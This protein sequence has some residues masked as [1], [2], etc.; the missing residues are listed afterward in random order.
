M[1][2]NKE[3]LFSDGGWC[4]VRWAVR[5]K[6]FVFAEHRIGCSEEWYPNTAHWSW[7]HDD[8]RL[9]CWKCGSVCPEE[10]R[11]LVILYNFDAMAK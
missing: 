3:V 11:G 2:D 5:T 6:V 8:F 4:I 1:R 7:E 9:G 10:V